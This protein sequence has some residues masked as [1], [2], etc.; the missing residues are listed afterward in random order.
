MPQKILKWKRQTM[1]GRNEYVA[2]LNLPGCEK[3]TYRCALEPSGKLGWELFKNAF[4]LMMSGGVVVRTLAFIKSEAQ[5][6][7]DIVLRGYV[8]LDWKEEKRS[9][10]VGDG[11]EI[12][13]SSKAIENQVGTKIAYR[14]QERQLDRG[15]F[16]FRNGMRLYTLKAPASVDDC[17]KTAQADAREFVSGG[18][19]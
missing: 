13:W 14:I 7:A 15:W 17:M 1:E 8:D 12:Q 19:H 18:K 16:L 11:M 10:S 2:V 3:V 4:C 5:V 9:S 6:D